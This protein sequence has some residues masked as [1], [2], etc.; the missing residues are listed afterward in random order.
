MKFERHDQFRFNHNGV[1]ASDL[2]CN[3]LA[4]SRFGENIPVMQNGRTT[5]ALIA[6]FSLVTLSFTRELHHVWGLCDLALGWRSALTQECL[7]SAVT[8]SSSPAYG[9]LSATFSALFHPP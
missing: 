1:V 4:Q 8:L 7:T 9:S 2:K 5:V 6:T 3:G